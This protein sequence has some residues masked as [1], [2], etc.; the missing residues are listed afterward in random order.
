[1]TDEEVVEIEGVRA[2]SETDKGLLV[3]VKSLKTGEVREVWL[4]KSHIHDDSEVYNAGTNAEGSLV[5]P[6]WLAE[7]ER[8]I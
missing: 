8:L 1:M 4:P 2:I 7:N 3:K 6:L 5:I